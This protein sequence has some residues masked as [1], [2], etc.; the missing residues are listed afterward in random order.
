MLTEARLAKLWGFLPV[1]VRYADVWKLVYSP[2]VHGVSLRTLYRQCDVHPGPTLV[3][4]QDESSG[5]VFGG[6]ASH[7]WHCVASAQ[8]SFYGDP[9]CFVFRFLTKKSGS[10]REDE[11]QEVGAFQGSG[12]NEYCLFSDLDGLNMG[13][14][15]HFA[16]WVGEDLMRGSSDKCCTFGTPGP[17]GMKRD[18]VTP[19]LAVWGFDLP[20]KDFGMSSMVYDGTGSPSEPTSPDSRSPGR[21]RLGKSERLRGRAS[22]AKEDVL[23]G[24]AIDGARDSLR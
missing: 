7:T 24:M 23:G 9:A 14:G 17:L 19:T 20:V 3:I 18:F 5:T 16:W 13:G 11:E 8:R 1:T 21:S 15:D 4:I 10:D 12:S 6:Y 2:R 22:D